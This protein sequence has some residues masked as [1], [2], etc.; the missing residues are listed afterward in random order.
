MKE[1]NGMQFPTVWSDLAIDPEIVE[2]QGGLDSE[3]TISI[4]CLMDWIEEYVNLA[5]NVSLDVVDDLLKRGCA[6]QDYLVSVKTRIHAL[7]KLRKKL[8]DTWK[9][10]VTSNYAPDPGEKKISEASRERRV[11]LE[12]DWQ[13]H[14]NFIIRL[15]SMENWSEDMLRSFREHLRELDLRIQIRLKSQ[16]DFPQSRT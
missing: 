3:P 9:A 1:I 8:Y 10:Q 13:L 4:A 2:R 5:D 12:E 14:Q 6:F 11:I 15:E 16:P 7:H